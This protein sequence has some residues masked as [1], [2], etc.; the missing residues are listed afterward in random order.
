MLSAHRERSLVHDAESVV[1]RDFVADL[2]V[3]HSI[4]MFARVFVVDTVDFGR[5]END[6]GPYFESP[7]NSSGVG[8]EVG[9][10]GSSG[11][12]D[13]TAF[14]KVTVC[15]AH[16]KRFGDLGNRDGLLNTSLNALTFDRILECQRIDHGP[17]HSHL[18]GD[19]SVVSALC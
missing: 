8:R 11:E 3:S 14:F 19:T 5:F 9:I 2:F 7:E 17:K 6:V 15:S 13:D 12:D 18:V 4:G 10:S 1:D 16:N